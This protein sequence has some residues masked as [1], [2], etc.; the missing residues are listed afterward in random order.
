M[1]IWNLDERPLCR[2]ALQHLAKLPT[3]NKTR[4]N[5]GEKIEFFTGYNDDIRAAATIK[6]ISGDEIY[7]YN[8]CYWYP[9]KDDQRR[10]IRKA[11]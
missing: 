8:D 7:V 1:A 5:V 6:A 4:F 11:V 10:K 3:E 2:D 9:I